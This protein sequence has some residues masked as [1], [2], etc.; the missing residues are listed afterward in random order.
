MY[1]LGLTG[2]IATG[3]S[4]VLKAFSACGVPVF[5]ADQA[6][7]DLYEGE[8]VAPVGALFPDA[9]VKGKIDRQ[10]LSRVL[11]G[12]GQKLRQLEAVV[13]PLVRA[14]IRDFLDAAEKTGEKLA[15]VE[16]PLL[17]ESGHDYGFDG[18]AVTWCAPEIQRRRALERPAMNVEKLHAILARQMPQDEKRKGA[19][20]VFD[21]GIGIDQTRQEVTELVAKLRG[22]SV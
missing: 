1:R 2:S 10:A 15:V 14:K 12:D 9:I 22:T 6:V 8:T 7:H 11:M 16:V 3:K 13:H 17:F 5:S 19:D 4:T 18:V 20:F 21:T